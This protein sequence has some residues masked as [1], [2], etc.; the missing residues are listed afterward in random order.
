MTVL[1]IYG[2]PPGERIY[3]LFAYIWKST[4]YYFF[5]ESIYVLIVF[6]SVYEDCWLFHALGYVHIK[7]C[8]KEIYGS[9]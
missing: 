7:T 2:S 8:I 5:N 3:H 4:F 1:Y 6:F 9:V